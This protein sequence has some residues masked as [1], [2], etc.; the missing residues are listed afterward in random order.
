QYIR[1]FIEDKIV[2]RIIVWQLALRKINGI[3]QMEK[4]SALIVH[5]TDPINAEPPLELLRKQFITP[6][7]LFYVRN[8]GNIPRI[9][10]KSYRLKVDGMV[11]NELEISMDSIMNDYSKKSVMA[12]VQCAGNRRTELL[13]VAPIPGEVPW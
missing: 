3:N 8:H 5:T 10:I 1:D 12:T 4:H 11:E 6:E 13:S 7:E 9:D 2:K